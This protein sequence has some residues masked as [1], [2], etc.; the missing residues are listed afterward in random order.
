MDEFE[1]KPKDRPRKSTWLVVV[2]IILVLLL[3]GYLVY[4]NYGSQILDKLLGKQGQAGSSGSAS[5]NSSAKTIGQSSV[6]KVTDEG[7]T[8]QTPEKLGDLGLFNKND[9][10]EGL[11]GYNGTVYYKVGTTSTGGEIIVAASDPYSMGDVDIHRIIK[12]DGKYYLLS[13][14]S[15]IAEYQSYT[16]SY[17]LTDDPT[18]VFKSLSPEK[19]FTKG[20]TELVYQFDG[21][22]DSQKGY[23]V[24]TKIG[25]TK[26]GDL[27]VE[28]GADA[29]NSGGVVKVSRYYVK[30]ND[31]TRAYYLPRPSFLKDD[32]TFNATFT[33]SDKAS[34]TFEKMKTSGCGG[35]SGS[36]PLITQASALT[37]KTEIAKTAKGGKL[38]TFTDLNNALI[39]FAYEVYTAGTTE[40]V[41]SKADFAQNYGIVIWVDDYNNAILYSNSSYVLPVECGKPVI[42]LYPTHDTQVT[43][44]VGASITKSEPAYGEGW[45]VLAKTDGSIITN[46]IKYDSLFWEGFGWGPYPEVK[47]GIVVE[48]SKVAE[49]ITENLTQIGLNQKEIS[50]FKDFWLPK[51]PDT[52]LVRLT[53]FLN[54]DMDKLAPLAISPKPDS[55]I[56]VFLDYAG[57]NEPISI[58][59]QVLP[60]MPRIG[61]T[62]VEWGGLL[63]K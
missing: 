59:L 63:R 44:K 48:K 55:L 42:Y 26:W 8:W 60:K 1:S 30:M 20:E 56:R 43:V 57:S 3:G 5:T 10:F 19:A 34:L 23:S 54:A 6:D 27:M 40:G 29:G 4:Q 25:D 22:I 11:A 61:F 50:D 13:K 41:K 28:Q 7:V 9:S 37:G 47:S 39:K 53:W 31:S 21:A 14:N 12:R 62:A 17:Q 35:G 46:H 32:K 24:A 51:M 52:K 38:Y 15:S 49:T 45:K 33:S 16:A 36:F 58:A 18:F 2:L